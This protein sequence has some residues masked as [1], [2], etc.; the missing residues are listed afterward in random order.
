MKF[1]NLKLGTVLV[2]IALPA[3]TSHL[4]DKL[5]VVVMIVV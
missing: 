5:S 4:I 1:K 3:V 2:V